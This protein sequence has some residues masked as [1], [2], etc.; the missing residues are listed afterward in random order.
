[1][2]HTFELN[3]RPFNAIKAG[4]K[5]VEVRAPK[6]AHDERYESMVSGDTITFTNNE[7][8]EKI[9]CEVLFVSHYSTIRTMLETEGTKNVLSSG[10]NVEQG[11]ESI[12]SLGDYK[13]RIE[14]WGVYAI[15]LKLENIL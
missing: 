6:S 9:V 13:E 5:N 12:N 11:I 8:G 4:T 3:N 1:M 10:G 2:N 14:K 15:G 7:T